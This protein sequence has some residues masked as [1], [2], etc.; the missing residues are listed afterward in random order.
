[1]GNTRVVLLSRFLRLLLCIG[2]SSIF[3]ISFSSGAHF[4]VTCF[5]LRYTLSMHNT[6]TMH[7]I[8]LLLTHMKDCTRSRGN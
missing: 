6:P 8:Y 1:M 7:G 5:F 2:I 4:P 3:R